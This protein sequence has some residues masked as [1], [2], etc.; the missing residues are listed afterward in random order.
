MNFLICK[1]CIMKRKPSLELNRGT[2]HVENSC[3]LKMTSLAHF[4]TEPRK[5][6]ALWI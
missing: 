1:A 3:L 6:V 4:G 2:T 5:D